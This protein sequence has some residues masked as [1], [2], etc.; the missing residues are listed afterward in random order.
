M[1][2]VAFTF[3][4]I[5]ELE[6]DFALLLSMIAVPESTI[7][8]QP[9]PVSGTWLPRPVPVVSVKL[10]CPKVPGKQGS[11]ANVLPVTEAESVKVARPPR[12]SAPPTTRTKPARR[13]RAPVLCMSAHLTPPDARTPAWAACGRR[14]RGSCAGTVSAP[15]AARS[16]PDTGVAGRTGT[17]AARTRRAAGSRWPRPPELPLVLVQSDAPACATPSPAPSLCFGVQAHQRRMAP[18]PLALLAQPRALARAGRQER[19][20]A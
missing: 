13:K 20:A 11:V 1:C 15:A 17:P 7:E 10:S 2:Q 9:P 14:G 18:A 8:V 4:R 12:A 6:L 16:R 19:S 3:H 5:S